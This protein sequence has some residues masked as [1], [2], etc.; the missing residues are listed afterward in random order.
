MLVVKF[1]P[2]LYW[3]IIS[4]YTDLQLVPYLVP[5]YQTDFRVRAYIARCWESS[6]RDARPSA[7][8]LYA[9]QLAVCHK[10]GFGLSQDDNKSRS[11]WVGAGLDEE[12]LKRLVSQVES[13]NSPPSYWAGGSYIKL[14]KDGHDVIRDAY[15]YYTS[16]NLV[17]EAIRCLRR[18]ILSLQKG[19]GSQCFLAQVLKSDLCRILRR[20]GKLDEAVK[21]AEDVVNTM[22]SQK[23]HQD[24]DVLTSMTYL[25]AIKMDLGRLKDAGDLLENIRQVQMA[26]LGNAHPNTLC[27]GKLLASVSRDQ[28]Q[29][30]KARALL[31]EIIPAEEQVLGKNHEETLSS[32]GIAASL[33]LKEHRLEEAEEMLLEIIQARLPPVHPEFDL[34]KV[35]EQVAS[36]DRYDSGLLTDLRT[37]AAIYHHQGRLADAQ[38][39]QLRLARRNEESLGKD[40]HNTVLSKGDLAS[41]LSKLGRTDEALALFEEVLAASRK[42]WRANHPIVLDILGHMARTYSILGNLD[43]AKDLVLEKA[44]LE[45][46]VLGPR[47][48]STLATAADL[49]KLY[50]DLD[51]P[52]EV[53]LLLSKVPLNESEMVA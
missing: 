5:L 22:K 11:L 2:L 10:L 20:A 29:I 23:G 42:I 53:K 33:L 7:E 45:L 51:Q 4:A 1:H 30:T 14:M 15:D 21:V 3:Q 40:H 18:E 17:E 8:R 50:L 31:E 13:I 41:T 32:K 19:I 27:T 16:Q 47:H 12:E 37:L 43:R 44:Q 46:D 48:P 24:E 38:R 26:T 28:G 6:L 25:S 52:A 36:H 35:L 34:Q 9:S 49:E 39:V